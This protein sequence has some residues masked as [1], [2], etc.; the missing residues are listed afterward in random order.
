MHLQTK[1]AGS[2]ACDQTAERLLHFVIAPVQLVHQ[3]HPLKGDQRVELRLKCQR[4][5]Q[6]PTTPVLLCYALWHG[7]SNFNWAVN[8]S[9]VMIGGEA[10]RAPCDVVNPVLSIV[11]S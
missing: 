6:R 8:S 9:I 1:G 5:R 2:N 4:Q 3:L 7:T 11:C 10:F